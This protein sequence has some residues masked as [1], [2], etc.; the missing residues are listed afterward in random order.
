MRLGGY[1]P[2]HLW[3]QREQ[4]AEEFMTWARRHR[5]LWP[6]AAIVAV[7]LV[8][9]NL[10][11]GSMFDY[12][13]LETPLAYLPLLPLFSIGIGLFTAHR[14]RNAPTGIRDK[15]VDLLI[16]I[17]LIVLAMVLITVVPALAST[18]YWSNRPDVLSMALFVAGLITIFYGVTWM[19]RLKASLVFLVL[20][21]PA[22][23]LNIMPGIMQSFTDAT[24]GALAK[25]VHLLPL[26]VSLG[27][28]PGLLLVHQASG[29]GI[30]VSVGTACSGA[31]SVLGFLLIG[32]AIL[33]AVKGGKLR[34]LTWMA[35]GLALTFAVNVIRLTSILAL[36]SAGH[37]D[38]AL[39]GYHAVIGLILFTVV[40]AVMM[41]LLPIFRMLPRD[42]VVGRTRG[43]TASPARRLVSE[44]RRRVVIGTMVGLALLVGL[45]DHGL[46]PYAAFQDGTGS[47]SVHPFSTASAP[48]GYRVSYQ[49]D[50]PWATQYFGTNSSFTRYLVIGTPPSPKGA[51][52]TAAASQTSVVYA[53]VVRTDDR[54][55]LDAYN[56]QNC[57]LF[58][59]Y[60]ITTS[61]RID[62]GSGV[63]ALL[64][65]YADPA[66]NARWA[67]VS[68]AWPVEN[69]GQT[70]YERI[71]LTSSLF[72]SG[73]DA[74]ISPSGGLHGL[75]VGFLNL[76]N[77]SHDDPKTDALFKN[78]DATLR[79]D[80]ETLVKFAV[81]QKN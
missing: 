19:W 10:T 31:D 41:R 57:F 43:S 63:T 35:V 59:N 7:T 32:G 15:Q 30:L 44:R 55:S 47:P 33:T 46:A 65:N 80:A 21:W 2:K 54:G 34:K 20:M 71:A 18:Y 52:T 26:G 73:A 38:L 22:L 37:P 4:R 58:H 6:A 64:L 40:V 11:L 68:W 9:Y 50:Y 60:S 12:L 77:G 62:I 3:A 72:T 8:A 76:L 28:S 25:V 78:A 1:R 49:A 24:N 16:G 79:A 36:A 29:P 53:D 61:Q 13:R 23:Y 5:A 48:P 45:T 75:L 17:P 56:L 39:G 66:S 70:Y 27:G 51:I 67:T 74:D 42:D 14:Y 81:Q 69:K